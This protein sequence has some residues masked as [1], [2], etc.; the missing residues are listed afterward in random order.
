[1]A[2]RGALAAVARQLEHPDAAVRVLRRH[3][4]GGVGAAVVDHQ[5][6]ERFLPPLQVGQQLREAVAEARRLV[7]GGDDDT[8]VDLL[9]GVHRGRARLRAGLGHAGR[10]VGC[11]A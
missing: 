4:G 10:I 6:L 8:E 11:Q 2:Q 5:H 7:E 9:R 1:M 3:L